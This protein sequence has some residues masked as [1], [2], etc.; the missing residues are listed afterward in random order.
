MKKKIAT[1]CC[2]L[3]I[4]AALNSCG[5]VPVDTATATAA[6]MNPSLWPEAVYPLAPDPDLE[7][8]VADLLAQMSLEE[9][10]GQIIQPEIKYATPADVKTYHLG[11]VLNGGGTAPN[12]DSSASL[13]DWV[14]L[15][16]QFYAASMDTSDGK[17]AIPLLWGSDAVHG[18]NNVVGATLFPHNIGLGAA[19]D[20]DLI[21]RIGEVTA[22]E[23][24]ATGIDWTFAP[25]VAVVRDIR[26]GRTYESYSE[27]P[28]LVSRYA[29]QMVR[30]LQGDSSLAGLAGGRHVVATAKH[31]LG[32]GGTYRGIDRGDT[33]SGEQ[34]LIDIHAAGFIASLANGVQTV[35]ASFNSWNGVKMHANRYLLTDIL[36]TRLGFDG[37]VVSD[38]NAHRYVPG[39]TVES[40]P[41]VVNAGI[42]MLMVPS[43][44]KALYYNTLAQ[45]RRGDIP[46][47]RL[48]DAV[49]RI[50]RVKMRAGLFQ[51]GPVRS[52]PLAGAGEVFGT[53]AHRDIAREAVRK[54]LVLLKN[55]HNLLPLKRGQNVLVAG[56]AADD[57]GK[58][59]GGWSLS[60][61]GSVDDNE[62]FVGATSIFQGIDRLVSAAGGQALLRENGDWGE[63][64]FANGAGPDVAVVVFGEEPYAEWHGDIAGIEYQAG[65]K[66]DLE[67]LQRLRSEGI[68]VVAVFITGRP[69]WV[70][71]EIN[72]ADAFVVAWLPGSEGDGVA[73]VLFRDGQGNIA[74]DSSGRLPFSWPREAHQTVLYQAMDNYA[75]LFP[76]GFGLSY[77]DEVYLADDLPEA[78]NQIGAERLEDA[79]VFVSRA[80][81]PWQLQLQD[82]RFAAV[83]MDGNRAS[84]GADDNLTASAVDKVAQEDARRIK[85]LGLAP[86]TLSFAARSPQDLSAYLQTEAALMFDIRKHLDPSAEV[87]LA[88]HCGD[89]CTAALAINPMLTALPAD[90]WRRFTLD[91]ACLSPQGT[92]FSQVDR[93]LSISSSGRLEISL[94]NVKLVPQL[95]AEADISCSAE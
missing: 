88:L 15:A 36:K 39:C 51:A 28:S 11:S 38:W 81:G 18:H 30:G 82:H 59:S 77:T 16:Q 69:L 87:S 10:V 47:A 7:Q 72:A 42:D 64:S 75:P 14:D 20:P 40:C 33:R 46:A 85:W 73:E 43:D 24:K 55:N 68:A 32:D 91:L 78:N 92:D 71:K 25:T 1:T 56:D 19:R 86:A 61:Q 2:V 67:L 48:D 89:D 90:E 50:L 44:W 34:E 35:M 3:S 5:K 12:N 21:R 66:R 41:Q 95:G 31:Y 49:R 22:M 70:N 57:I 65:S 83:E 93:V 94:A 52:R 63:A 8:K 26:W 54:S 80:I 9:K 62:K 79:W 74:Y 17:V 29:E 45:A 23:V 53:A 4:A 37:F 27:D 13:A 84:S 76:Y 60:W 6:A 58:Q